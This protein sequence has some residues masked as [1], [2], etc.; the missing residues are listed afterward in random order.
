MFGG[1]QSAGSLSPLLLLDDAD[2]AMREY[3]QSKSFAKFSLFWSDHAYAPERHASF[4]GTM[5]SMSNCRG[6]V[7]VWLSNGEYHV[8]SMTVQ[9][10][11]VV[12]GVNDS[13][14]RTS[15]L[16]LQPFLFAS[17]QCLNRSRLYV[18]SFV[19]GAL[20][21]WVMSSSHP[22]LAGCVSSVDV[23]GTVSSTGSGC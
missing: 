7:N 17:T 15:C 1:S 11:C 12:V 13:A 8:P 3:S 20:T 18:S 16:V 23:S 5:W 19:S 10:F 14:L 9:R 6:L 4:K 22:L 21:S 2:T